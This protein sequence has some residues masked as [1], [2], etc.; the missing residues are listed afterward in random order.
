V[1]SVR[2]AIRP[3]I[4]DALLVAAIVVGGALPHD[5]QGGA[6]GL[7][8]TVALALPLLVRRRRPIVAFALVALVALAQWAADVRAFGD[9]ALLIA[10][11]TVAATQPAARLAAAFA[12]IEIGIV[13]AT[14]RWA[15][16]KPL[17]V[18]VALSGLA[19][20][21]AV[22]GVN[23]RNRRA[24]VASLE[25]RATRL[26]HERDQQGRLAAAAERA[27][28][29]RE[30]HDIVAHNLSV[31]I[32]LADGA[33]FAVHDEPDRAEGAMGNIARTGRHALTE[34]RRLLGVLR[35]DTSRSEMAP[36]P[37]LR[38]I[39]ALVGQVRAA[40]LR[41][42]FAVEGASPEPLPPG[43]QLAAFRIVQ[44]ALTNTL[45][46]AGRDTSARVRLGFEHGALT[47]EVRDTGTASGAADAHEGGGLRGMRER[48]GV[49][50]GD[51]EAGPVPGGGWRV[52]T[53]LSA[54]GELIA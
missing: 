48:A 41:V 23:G 26:E 21:A 38:E 54:V 14:I 17:Y 12:V 50:G 52:Y 27:R 46:H 30:M 28:I 13:M 42:D 5:G 2:P 47:V 39:E 51:L 25:E 20:A 24:L 49:Y 36:L 45:K 32:A 37:G 11:Y 8:F 19:T 6:A 9:V 18:F 31:M 35:E 15:A 29:A 16:S 34:M 3:W 33:A 53:R 44:E 7:A 22:I 4:T 10:L 40:G 1:A 43:L